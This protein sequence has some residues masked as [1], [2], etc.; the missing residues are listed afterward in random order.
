M[1]DNDLLRSTFNK[2][3]HDYDAIRPGYP[4]R[5][6][7]DVI[8]LSEIPPSGLA[9]EIGCGTGQ[10]TLPFAQRGYHI[11]CLDI[12]PDLLEIAKKNLSAYANVSFENISFESWPLQA[13]KFD[14]VYAATAF[15]WIPPEIG[16]PKA[17]SALKPAGALALFSNIHPRPPTAFFVDVQSVYRQF[18]PEPQNQSEQPTTEAEIE[19]KVRFMR[20]TGL[21]S[22]VE[23]RTYP[24]T[25]T[26]TTAEYLQ[27]LNTY[28]DHL[29]MEEERR[30]QMYHAIADLIEKRYH[31]MVERLYLTVLYMG[32]KKAL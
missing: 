31:G 2:A 21:F 13:D 11:L 28:S 24:W 12:G 16:Y 25:K 23:V 29:L 4:N 27:L 3:A 7:E 30:Y 19:E 22:T 1:A 8:T 15:H 5:L 6:F 9:L 14:L 32:R 17:I 20:A 18:F 26:Y 10:A